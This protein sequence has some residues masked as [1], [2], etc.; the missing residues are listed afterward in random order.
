M[1]S[2][3]LPNPAALD[4]EQRL[5]LS[6]VSWE[7]YEALLQTFGNGFPT[8]RLSY[9]DGQLE[10]MTNSPAH[11]ELKKIIAMLLEA[12][13][14]ESNTRFHAGGST[15]F[16]Q[17]AKQRGLEPDECYC[18]GTR[19]ELPDLA[20][21]IVITRG[22]VDKLEIYR[23]LGIAEVWIW[24]DKMFTI[25]CLNSGKYVESPSS[26]LLPNLDMALLTAYVKP[27]Q[28]FDAVMAFRN[29]LRQ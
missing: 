15:T 14:Q 3:L 13:L 1:S 8:L 29:Q 25:Y 9:L 12:Y 23:G 11:E 16:R 27:Q 5:L 4:S 28:Q 22:L 18:L 24:Q 19:K 26:Q 21:E 20:I 6:G 10:I 7:Q 2:Q 17:A